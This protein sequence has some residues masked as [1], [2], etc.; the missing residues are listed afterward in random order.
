MRHAAWIA[1]RELR[2][3]LRDGRVLG[4]FLLPIVLYPLVFWALTQVLLLLDDRRPV[5]AW[6]GAVEV[7]E[8][9]AGAEVDWVD[10]GEAAYEA[11]E[12]DGWITITRGAAGTTLDGSIRAT[13]RGALRRGIANLRR[14][15]AQRVAPDLPASPPWVQLRL[16]DEE[17]L[18]LREV[19]SELAPFAPVAPMLVLMLALSMVV[20]PAVDAA[21]EHGR[22]TLTTTLIGPQHDRSVVWGKVLATSALALLSVAAQLAVTAVSVAHFFSVV[23]LTS[24]E[25]GVIGPEPPSGVGLGAAGLALTTSIVAA[26]AAFIA[27]CVPFKD[28][29]NA[30]S[31]SSFVTLG[32]MLWLGA[33]VAPAPWSL[34]MPIA[35]AVPITVEAMA[36]AVDPAHLAAACTVNAAATAALV[37][38]AAR[39]LRRVGTG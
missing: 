21:Q 18:D 12:A 34:L 28:P 36:G 25:R 32:L 5:L 15:E 14:S 22:G 26:S 27:A 23:L 9:M 4:M 33:G 37:E 11:G 30:L 17:P 7:P 16:A 31:A 13:D 3:S 8:A 1:E 10:G 6:D 29:Q 24:T 2:E 39:V 38:V 19:A 20:Y 35:N